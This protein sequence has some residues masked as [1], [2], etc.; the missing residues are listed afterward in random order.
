MHKLLSP[1]QQQ[2][3]LEFRQ[4]MLECASRYPEFLKIVTTGDEL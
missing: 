3:Q 2:F 4:D 1:E